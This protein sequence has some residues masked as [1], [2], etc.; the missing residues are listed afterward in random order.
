MHLLVWRRDFNVWFI[1]N[2]RLKMEQGKVGVQ[3][4]DAELEVIRAKKG[5][6][7]I[8]L[9]LDGV[10]ARFSPAYARLLTEETGITFPDYN[11]VEPETWYW[12]RDAGVTE[13][14]ESRV[15]DRIRKDPYF[16]Q[17]FKRYSGV[18]DFC[19]NL[20][21]T[22]HMIYFITD[23]SGIMPQ[24]QSQW[25][26][27]YHCHIPMPNVIISNKA[28]KGVICKALGVNVF[29]DDKAENIEDVWS[30]SPMTDCYMLKKPYNSRLHGMEKLVTSLDEFG[31]KAGLF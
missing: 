22:D 21:N 28:G 1:S 4:F 11:I 13:E 23:R 29:L 16:W 9:D 10:L 7:V 3:G 6:Q 17:G 15:W 27:K 30:Q 26:L 20:C 12:E 24:H 5:P 14:Q 25:W 19:E 8:G 2:E 18:N 31:A